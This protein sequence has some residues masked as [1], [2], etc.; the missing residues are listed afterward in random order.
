MAAPAPRSVAMQV[1]VLSDDVPEPA[2]HGG[3][4]AI[5]NEI[6]AMRLAG[7]DVR[8]IAFHRGTLPHPVVEANRALSTGFDAIHRPS[9]WRSP[10]RRPWLPYQVSSRLLHGGLG[11]IGDGLLPGVIICHHDWTVSAALHIS[12]LVGGAPV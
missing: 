7:Y 10:L 5:K 6:E 11:P 8:L 2:T 4:L 3:R 1:L 12:R 9:L